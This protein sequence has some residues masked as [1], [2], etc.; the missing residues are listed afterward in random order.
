MSPEISLQVLLP[1]AQPPE[2]FAD[3]TFCADVEEATDS[4][5]PISLDIVTSVCN[6]SMKMNVS[7]VFGL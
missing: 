2:D 3:Q 1:Y 7:T 6:C 4:F 5:E